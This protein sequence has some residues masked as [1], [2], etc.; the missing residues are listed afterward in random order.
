M[1]RD[2]QQFVRSAL[3]GALLSCD[4]TRRNAR[5]VIEVVNA[6]MADAQSGDNYAGFGEHTTQ[7]EQTGQVVSL[8]AVDRRSRPTPCRQARG[9]GATV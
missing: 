6:V 3:G 5:Q 8:P 4:H 1:F 7:S 9:P 2:A